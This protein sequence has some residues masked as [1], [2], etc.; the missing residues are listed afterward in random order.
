MP[1]AREHGKFHEVKLDGTPN[2][3]NT[4][5]EGGI[6]C[7]DPRESPA[8]GGGGAEGQ[9]SLCGRSDAGHEGAG[10]LKKQGSLARG[11]LQPETQ[12]LQ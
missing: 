5:Q 9:P 12:L 4:R 2:P 11:H 7:T 8:K 10:S 1:E 6:P 3:A